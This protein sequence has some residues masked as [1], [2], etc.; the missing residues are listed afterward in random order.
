MILGLYEAH[1]PVSQLERSVEFY[2]KLGLELAWKTEDIAFFWI[3]KE[4]SWL[5]LWEGEAYK[6]PYDPSL[7]HIAFRV[8]YEEL[9]NSLSWLK[10]IGVEA[11]PFGDRDSVEP[12]VRPNQ[13]NASVYFKDFDG[14]S[15]EF[16]CFI[17]VPESLRK[18]S[19]KLS[20]AEWEEQLQKQ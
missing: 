1:L 11:V 5:G 20:F 15:L 8:G 10:S 2:T 12:F 4:K 16:M 17:S 9:K 7:R 19:D 13:G 6:T 3:E 18:V 14:N